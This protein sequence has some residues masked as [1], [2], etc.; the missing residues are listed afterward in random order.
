MSPDEKPRLVGR[1]P[2]LPRGVPRGKPGG[3]Q[4]TP[5]CAG[6]ARGY[7]GHLSVLVWDG[8]SHKIVSNYFPDISIDLGIQFDEWGDPSAQLYP[9]ELRGEIDELNTYLLANINEGVHK[10]AGAITQTDYEELR[11]QVIAALEDLDERLARSRFLF[12]SEITESDVR[13]WVTL[14][15]FDLLHNPQGGIS[16]RRLTDFPNLWA[17]ARD[18]YQRPA[19]RDTT[20]FSTFRYAP[21]LDDLDRIV[22][23]RFEADWEQP[24]GRERL[25]L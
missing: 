6:P 25:A 8:A 17:Y 14:A 10:V 5:Q 1:Q 4:I 11:G 12:G 16:E 3:V 21:P 20:D 22:V 19:F 7:P 2:S 18:L 23:E 13:L 15:R 9:V 24:H